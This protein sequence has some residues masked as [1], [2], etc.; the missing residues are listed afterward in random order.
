V[1]VFAAALLATL[2]LIVA[3]CRDAGDAEAGSAADAPFLPFVASGPTAELRVAMVRPPSFRPDE[4]SLSDQAGMV[5]ADLLYDGLTEVDGTT[6]ELR[7]ALARSWTP[8]E[9]FQRWTFEL[10]PGAEI[11]ADTVVRALAALSTGHGDD[12]SPKRTSASLTAGLASVRAVGNRTVVVELE[13]PNAGLP[14]ILSGV[15]YS[16]AGVDGEPTG[17][18]E[19]GGS[20]DA[21]L[22]LDRRSGRGGSLGQLPSIEVVWAEQPGDTY[23][24]LLDDEIDAAVVDSRSLADARTQLGVETNPSTAVRFYVLNP[25]SAELADRDRRATLLELVDSVALLDEV[26]RADVTLVDGLLPSSMAG[27]RAD[28]CG[29]VCG[30]LDDGTGGVGS[31]VTPWPVEVPLRVT[32][33]GAGQAATADALATQL[34]DAG[35]SATPVEATAADL[36]SAIVEG[37]PDLFAFGWVA[38]AGVADA[39]L[40]PLLR[41]DSPANVARFESPRIQEL[42]DAAARTGDDEAR[43][44]LLD[45]AHRLALVEAKVLPVATSTGTMVLAPDLTGVVIRTD[46][47]LDLERS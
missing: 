18:Y 40:P 28:G 7:A 13:R 35:V 5:V 30:E 47:T 17:D 37:S 33:A 3:G 31:D 16:I 45:E 29:E 12:P 46:G 11:D 15:P 4:V 9:A 25:G 19:I 22:R 8:D 32:F 42:L 36:A 43:W 44:D 20:G 26:G 2:L 1:R 21:S 24:M 41:A 38:P 23:R 34:R 27:Y 6:G 10:D 14:W 39:V